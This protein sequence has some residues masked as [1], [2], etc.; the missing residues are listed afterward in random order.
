MHSVKKISCRARVADHSSNSNNSRAASIKDR[1]SS[2]HAIIYS[3]YKS[4]ALKRNSLTTL[5]AVRVR[6]DNK[7]I[8]RK[9]YCCVSMS[10][11]ILKKYGL[12][13]SHCDCHTCR[14]SAHIKAAHRRVRYSCSASAASSSSPS[15][16]SFGDSFADNDNATNDDAQQNSN[17]STD[18]YILLGVKKGDSDDDI[19]AAV[20]RNYPRRREM[21]SWRR[22][23]MRHMIKSCSLLSTLGCLGKRK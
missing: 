21:K 19:R 16:S 8:K 18:P 13:S 17:A 12:S 7:M 14:Y 6:G 4:H 20:R 9:T 23:S 2:P 10:N 1:K 3:P 22:K 11:G 5:T 15:P